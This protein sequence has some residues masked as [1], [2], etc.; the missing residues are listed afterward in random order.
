MK[1]PVLLGCAGLVC[2]LALGGCSVDIGGFSFMSEKSAGRGATT[3]ASSAPASSGSARPAT[4]EARLTAE[5]E[6]DGDVSSSAGAPPPTIAEGI[7]ECELVKLKGARPTDVLIGDSGKG[8]REAQVLYAEPGGREIYL[9]VD[10]RL[11]RIIK[12]GQG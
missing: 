9:F 5:G 3:T 11:T 1:L 7:T 6:C 4:R 8:Q 12:P 10:N 2:T